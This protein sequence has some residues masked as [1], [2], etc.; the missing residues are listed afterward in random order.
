MVQV[1]S[2][3]IATLGLDGQFKVWNTQG[4]ELKLKHQ[5]NIASP[6]LHCFTVTSLGL[7]VGTA[8]GSIL[9]LDLQSYQ[10]VKRVKFHTDLPTNLI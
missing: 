3:D 4:S 1:N 5:M 9:F 6:Y 8:D 7:S 10:I 2:E